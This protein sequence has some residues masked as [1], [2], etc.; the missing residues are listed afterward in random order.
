[1]LPMAGTASNSFRA[2]KCAQAPRKYNLA[3]VSDVVEVQAFAPY[4]YV[5]GTMISDF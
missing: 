5:A 2:L 3:S 1:M 4:I